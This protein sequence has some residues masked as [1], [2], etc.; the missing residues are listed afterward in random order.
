MGFCQ[1][2]P[3]VGTTTTVFRSAGRERRGR[4]TEPS[5]SSLVLT[6]YAQMPRDSGPACSEMPSDSCPIGA[7]CALLTRSK[8]PEEEW[9][10]HRPP[11]HP[12]VAPEPKPIVGCWS[13]RRAW[14]YERNPA[15]GYEERSLSRI[16]VPRL[17]R[18][19]SA[20]AFFRVVDTFGYC[21]VGPVEENPGRASRHGPDS[22]LYPSQ[23]GHR[24]SWGNSP[25]FI[26]SALLAPP[27]G[28][29][30]VPTDRPRLQRQSPCD[31]VIYPWR[32]RGGG[33]LG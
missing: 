26:S 24:E 13:G 19:C 8:V 21:T 18:G 22:G 27:F 28:I 5:K 7:Q 14:H 6:R 12:A 11:F 1:G 10:K 23:D 3:V 29:P 15:L 20:C 9:D 30:S 31:G 17:A 16:F 32:S 33:R 4:E 25:G 2:I